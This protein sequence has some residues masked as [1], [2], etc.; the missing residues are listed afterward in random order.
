MIHIHSLSPETHLNHPPPTYVIKSLN[1]LH[2]TSTEILP[3]ASFSDKELI[4]WL[5]FNQHHPKT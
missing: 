1:H 3:I 4:L 2:A 5:V